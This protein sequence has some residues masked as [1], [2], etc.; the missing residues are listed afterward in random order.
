M[1]SIDPDRFL[2]IQFYFICQSFYCP[3]TIPIKF[4]IC[5]ALLRICGTR[6]IFKYSLW[7]IMFITALAGLGSMIGIVVS[8]SPTSAF[9]EPETGTCNPTVNAAA[10]YFISA[11]SI[12]T[13]FALAILPGL[14]LWNVQLKRTIKV[15]VGIILTLAAL[16]VLPFPVTGNPTNQTQRLHRHPRPSPL[17]PRPPRQPEFPRRLR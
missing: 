9:W 8:C 17:S 10:A 6:F 4:S 16:C 3:T 13:D 7:I 1:S 12:L 11:C 15:S 2:H 14:M 5:V